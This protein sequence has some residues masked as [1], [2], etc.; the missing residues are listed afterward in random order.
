MK[1]TV[2]GVMNR[3]LALRESG[4]KG[5]VVA[6]DFNVLCCTIRF[7]PDDSCMDSLMHPHF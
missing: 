6:D 5:F 7:I 4:V 1:Q 3:L 2:H